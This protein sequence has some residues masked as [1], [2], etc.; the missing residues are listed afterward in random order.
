MIK[1]VKK[2]V[3]CKKASRG[4]RKRQNEICDEISQMT[5]GCQH[6]SK[7]MSFQYLPSLVQL[8]LTFKPIQTTLPG[9]TDLHSP[10][11]IIANAIDTFNIGLAG[12]WIFFRIT[13]YSP[14][15]SFSV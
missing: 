9:P 5:T 14:R 10:A 11:V 3:N 12:K 7:K 2:F 15:T 8:S 13:S 4:R 1:A 6:L